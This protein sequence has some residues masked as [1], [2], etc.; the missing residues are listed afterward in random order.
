MGTERSELGCSLPSFAVWWQLEL[1]RLSEGQVAA[2]KGLASSDTVS[3]SS[4]SSA[5][6]IKNTT[7]LTRALPGTGI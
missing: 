6:S 2:T 7:P 3:F 5:G 4:P 1:S